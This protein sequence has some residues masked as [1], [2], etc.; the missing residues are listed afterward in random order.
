MLIGG[1]CVRLES[2]RHLRHLRHVGDKFR[3]FSIDFEIV[4]DNFKVSW[5]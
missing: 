1:R 4:F 5:S 3:I 2:L